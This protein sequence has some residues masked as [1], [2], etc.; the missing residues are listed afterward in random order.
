MTKV[1]VVDDNEDILES[2]ASLLELRGYE[3]ATLS[4]AGKVLASLAERPPDILLQDCHMPGLD[5]AA[6]IRAIRAQPRLHALPILLFT[7]STD[8]AESWSAVGANGLVWKPFEAPELQRAI[9]RCLVEGRAT[10]S[11]PH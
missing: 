3:V 6:L 1:L 9:E 8:A 7:A 2:T 10:A 5:L 4:N 11:I